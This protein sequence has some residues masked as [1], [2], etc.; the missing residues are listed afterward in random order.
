MTV[1]LKDST[2]QMEC[3][4]VSSYTEKHIRSICRQ[5][6][7]AEELRLSSFLWVVLQHVLLNMKLKNILVLGMKLETCR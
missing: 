4:G 7:T 2:L 6:E 3:R 5:V 1:S